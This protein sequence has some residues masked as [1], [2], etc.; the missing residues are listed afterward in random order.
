VTGLATYVTTATL[1]IVTADLAYLAFLADKHPAQ[2][3][4]QAT[5][6]LALVV[7]VLSVMAGGQGIFAIASK[8]S[9]GTWETMSGWFVAETLFALLGV[10]VLVVSILLLT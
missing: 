6:I 2:R 9:G 5:A 8:G 4:P 10:V 1:V 7:L 3:G